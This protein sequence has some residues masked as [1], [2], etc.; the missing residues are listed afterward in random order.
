VWFAHGVHF[1]EAEITRL[2]GARSGIAHCPSSNMRLGAGACPVT[3][4]L[5]AG[6]R[7]GLGVDGAASN[8]D[9]HLAGEV[10]Q[11]MLLARVRVA[12]LG[13]L[14]G[15]TALDAR[16][17]WRLATTGGAECLGWPE[18]GALEPGRRCDVALFRV[19]DLMHSGMSDPL[20]ALALAPPA[21]AASVVVEGRV[22]VRDGRLANADEDELAADLRRASDRLR[23]AV[24]A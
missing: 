19:D 4:L 6:C 3:E 1:S 11:A 2:G 18:V 17:A 20:E 7:V 15:A 14:D 21:R 8:E 24:N 23:G 22:T 5:A 13:R 12:M 16:Q 9:Y 10:R